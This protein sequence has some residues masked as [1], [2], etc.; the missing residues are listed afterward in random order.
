MMPNRRQSLFVTVAALAFTAGGCSGPTLEQ[1]DTT[2]AVAVSVETAVVDR[3]ESTISVTG[4]VTLAP[5]ADWV[6]IA[7][8]AARIADLPKAEGETAQV[9]DV[10]VRF[11]IPSLHAELASRRAE[12]TAAEARLAAATTDVNRQVPLLARGVAAQ[13][14][15]DEARRAQ[16]EAQAAVSQAETAVT[17]AIALADRAVVRATFAGVIAKRWHNAGDFVE[18][19][20]SDPVLRVIDTARLQLAASVPVADI[21]RIVPGR[22]G[23][24]IGPSG[25]G[26]PIRVL[27]E[28]AAGRSDDDHGRGAA[29]VHEADRPDGRHGRAGRHRG[30]GARE[31]DRR[32]PPLPSCT[33][34]TRSSSS[35]STRTTRPTG[36]KSSLGLTAPDRVE[37]L[38][39]IAAGDVVVF[40]GQDELPD[41]GDRH[42][43]EMNPARLAIPSLARGA[44]PH[45]A[46][47][48]RPAPSPVLALP[49]Q[50]LPAARSSRASR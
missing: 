41:G 46:A 11:D 12:V 49:E 17:A 26:E 30:G 15:V 5:G 33:T 45:G 34:R 22:T 25:E 36:T 9:G 3:I 44:A 31:G 1:T 14:E 35:S 43:C 48:P 32:S 38:H 40:R 19:S 28:A 29:G 24:V 16:A 21:P 23:F 39:G 4:L 37:I 27:R 18:A 13:R 2:A 8:E 7:P 50:H 42:G 47:S 20:A 6:I 10:L